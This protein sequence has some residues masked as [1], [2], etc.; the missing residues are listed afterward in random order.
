MPLITRQYTKIYTDRHGKA[1]EVKFNV[2]YNIQTEEEKE[3]KRIY[4]G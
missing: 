3:K 1:K 2:K 4:R